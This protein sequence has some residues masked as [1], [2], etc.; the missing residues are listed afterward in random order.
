MCTCQNCFNPSS[1]GEVVVHPSSTP[2]SFLDDETAEVEA[3]K[4]DVTSPAVD[5]P[6]FSREESTRV[7]ETAVQIED[8]VHL[9]LSSMGHLKASVPDVNAVGVHITMGVM[10]NKRVA[11]HVDE[12]GIHDVSENPN[13]ERVREKR[14]RPLTP[15]SEDFDWEMLMK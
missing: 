14:F 10:G 9:F 1:S 3:L 4:L 7:E 5:D 13:F 2:A 8:D 12:D 6:F 15:E 11:L